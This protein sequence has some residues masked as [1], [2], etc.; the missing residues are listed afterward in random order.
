MALTFPRWRRGTT[1]INT[2]AGRGRGGAAVA[3]G[4]GQP[5]A[6][7]AA[8]VPGAARPPAHLSASG[9]AWHWPQP[10]APGGRRPAGAAWRQARWAGTPA[11]PAVRRLPV[12]CTGCGRGA[13][14]QEEQGLM[15]RGH[16][17]PEMPPQAPGAAAA[18]LVLP[19][20]PSTH[21]IC[22]RPIGL[23]ARWHASDAA[24]TPS[25]ARAPTR[26]TAMGRRPRDRNQSEKNMSIMPEASA[27]TRS[28]AVTSRVTA[29]PAGRP[30]QAGLASASP[31]SPVCPPPTV[32]HSRRP[33]ASSAHAAIASGLGS[34]SD[35]IAPPSAPLRP[36]PQQPGVADCCRCR[37]RGCCW[38]LGAARRSRALS[39]SKQHMRPS[40][41]AMRP[42]PHSRARCGT[43]RRATG[44]PGHERGRGRGRGQRRWRGR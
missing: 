30:Q 26:D 42:T 41:S 39:S 17:G 34:S 38:E 21:L 7:P 43:P 25:G 8:A 37:C 18:R 40:G 15:R 35:G 5:A 23:L 9:A 22:T 1:S 12:G 44:C 2:A 10:C 29:K 33:P 31:G 27:P 3:Q 32:P 13:P 20:P 28:D 36:P 6:S 16:R 14:G 4:Q 19:L 11:P 24:A